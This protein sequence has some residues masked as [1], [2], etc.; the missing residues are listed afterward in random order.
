MEELAS[1]GFSCLPAGE[2]RA[3][4][5]TPLHSLLITFDDGFASVLEHAAPV[6]SRLGFRATVF[7][8]SG[9]VGRRTRWT[10]R[11]AAMPEAEL[12]DT[13]QLREL[14]AL[15]WEVGAHS[16]THR[17]L[18]DLSADQVALE[19]SKSKADLEGWLDAGV[20]SFAYPYGAWSPSALDAVRQAGYETAWTT[21]PGHVRAEDLFLQPRVVLSRRAHWARVRA[22][23]GPILPT[24][25][26]GLARLAS[27]QGRRPRYS[28]YEPGTDC[29]RFDEQSRPV[30]RDGVTTGARR[31]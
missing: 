19:V 7:V 18:P 11:G 31:G 14:L 23:Q 27:W 8:I 6:M 2:W 10:S 29:S 24:V 15:G 13:S 26:K 1:H 9:G 12:M 20:S 21:R 25:H 3:A 28:K 22:A 16:V 17:F 5:S 30:R 4:A